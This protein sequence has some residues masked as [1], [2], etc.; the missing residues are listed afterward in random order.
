MHRMMLLA[1]TCAAA[2]FATTSSGHAAVINILPGMD[3]TIYAEQLDNNN[4]AATQMAVG[5]RNNATELR[6]G[7]LWFDI[8]SE[9]PAGV[10]IV[11]VILTMSQPPVGQPAAQRV[12]LFRLTAPW[13]EGGNSTANP[14]AGGAPATNGSATWRYSAFNT[15]EWT[16]PGGDFD[17]LS[18][19]FAMVHGDS[20]DTVHTWSSALLVT[21]VQNWLDNPGQNHGWIAIGVESA[22]NLMRRFYS[23]EAAG[24]PVVA[25][26][27]RPA[28]TITY[29]PQPA[30]IGLLALGACGMLLRRGR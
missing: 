16:T 2:A 8:A 23:R 30:S 10:T 11:D 29:I 26:D 13:Q 24:G 9:L 5:R 3:D 4:G 17:P 22:N 7:L 14:P 19:A 1:V 20:I 21:D 12:D 15:T 6:R 18:R 25:D 27:I 28:L